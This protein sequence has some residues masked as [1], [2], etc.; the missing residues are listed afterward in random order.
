[1]FRWS[2]LISGAVRRNYKLISPSSRRFSRPYV[3]PPEGP[4][5]GLLAMHVRRGDYSYHCTHFANWS[6]TYT[7]WAL[8]PQ[9]LDSFKVPQGAGGG[10]ASPEAIAAYH[11]VCWP[12][13]EQ[14]VERARLMRTLH[15]GLNRVYILTN[16]TPGYLEKLKSDLK[17]DGW[18]KISTS[19]D[20][21]LNWQEKWVAQSIDMSIAQRAEVFVG[22]GVSVW[23]HSN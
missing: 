23:L 19:Q 7:S 9:F 12:T 4:I 5:D 10:A 16:G 2:D 14:I 22:N 13:N 21:G 6:S 15:P 3:L 11:R 20:M 1:M 17:A 18:A 8:L